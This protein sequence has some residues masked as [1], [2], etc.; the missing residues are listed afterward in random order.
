MPGRC[1]GRPGSASVRHRI[2]WILC[3]ARTK[4]LAWSNSMPT[5]LRVYYLT[6]ARRGDVLDE[7]ILIALGSKQTPLTIEGGQAEETEQTNEGGINEDA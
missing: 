4:G 7:I 3:H 2:S 1:G 5:A 6:R